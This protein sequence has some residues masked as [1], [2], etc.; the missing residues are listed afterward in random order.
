MTAIPQY[1]DGTAGPRPRAQTP[2]EEL[3]VMLTRA[4]AHMERHD[5][6]SDYRPTYHKI[7]DALYTLELATGRSRRDLLA[8]STR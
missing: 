5:L 2:C 6:V 7:E 1:S 4:K 3:A 8:K